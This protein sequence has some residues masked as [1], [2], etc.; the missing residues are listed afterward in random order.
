MALRPGVSKEAPRMATERLPMRKTREVLRLRW[1]LGLTVRQ[2]ARSLGKS[3]KAF[4]DGMK[5][6]LEEPDTNSI[7]QKSEEKK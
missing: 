7:E 6:G 5:E 2:V 3:I 1:Q 4:K